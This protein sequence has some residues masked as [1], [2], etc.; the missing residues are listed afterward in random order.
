[1]LHFG[2]KDP[3]IGPAEIEKIRTAH[4]DLP[5]FLYD[6]GHGFNCDQRARTRNK[7]AS[8]LNNLDE[9]YRRLNTEITNRLTVKKTFITEYPDLVRDEN[10]ACC[11]KQPNSDR[12]LKQLDEKE[13]EWASTSVIA[14]LNQ[15]VKQAAQD[16]K[17]VYVS[18]IANQFRD[19]GY[20][21][22]TPWVRTFGEAKRVQGLDG[23]CELLSIF[24]S[25]GTVRDCL[26][27]SG[28]VHP[29]RAGHTAYK[30]SLLEALKSE[31]VITATD[32][33]VAKG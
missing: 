2:A 17:W 28:A 12:F 18:G 9:G 27:S 7:L 3:H 15:K 20:C 13:A 4:P 32:L 22:N 10:G 31:G 24:K 25:L 19:H 33:P 29:N 5:L 1:M 30:T 23:K 14:G 6:A 16:N 11:D 8:G 21:S 26:I